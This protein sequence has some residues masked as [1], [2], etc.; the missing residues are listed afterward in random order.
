M[1]KAMRFGV[2]QVEFQQHDGG[3]ASDDLTIPSA[4]QCTP[5][6]PSSLPL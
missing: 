4:M 6:Q 3:T 2:L 5:I 1:T